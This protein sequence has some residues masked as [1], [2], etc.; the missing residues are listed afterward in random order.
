MNRSAY[1]AS[2]EAFLDADE[3]AILG[4][5]APNGGFSVE[6]AQLSAWRYQIRHLQDVL[7]GVPSDQPDA[8]IYFEFVIPRMGK[9]VDVLLVL[10]GLIFILEYK[11]GEK[12]YPAHAVDQ[13]VDYA[14]DL[15]NF[16]ETSHH[17]I[18]VPVLV[19]TD[20]PRAG[21][22]EFADSKDDRVL[23]PLLS[24]A[25]SLGALLSGALEKFPAERLPLAAWERGRYLPTPTI[26]EA[27]RALYA[28]H[29]V[30]DISRSDAGEVDIAETRGLVERVIDRC[31]ATST[32][33][34]CFVTGVPGAGKTLVG[35]D[36]AM[37][38]LDER[39]ERSRVFLS[40]N[41]P[42]VGILHEALARDRVSQARAAGETLR[43][44]VAKSQIKAFL[45]NV[46]HFR[47]SC[48]V[49]DR[50]PIEHVALFD[51]AQRAWD[52]EQTS[53]FMQQKKDRPGF[54]QSEPDFLI[55]CMG[56]HTDWAVVV[57]LVGGGQEIHT[58]ESGID[59]W[60]QAIRDH[61]KDWDVYA[62]PNLSDREYNAQKTLE[63]LRGEGRAELHPQLHLSSCVRSF[64]AESLSAW[65][66]A[67][68]DGDIGRARKLSDEF[69]DRYPI[70]LTRCLDT[71]KAWARSQARG[72]ER[73]GLVVSSQAQ[74]LKPYAI[75]VKSPM[76]PVNWFLNDKD[77]VRSSYFLE[78]VATEFQVQG[79]ELDWA[80]VA[81]DADLR[82]VQSPGEYSWSHHSFRGSKW[83]RIKQA[84]RQRYQLNAY[85]VLLTRA[86]QGMVIFVPEGD[87]SDPTRRP[88]FY[89]DT[90]RY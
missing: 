28:R 72:T 54:H 36:V 50:P 58:G 48:L 86:R 24:N 17:A 14:L 5:L 40:G 62:S 23:R 34:I 29:A 90:Y 13:V 15:K 11:V 83:Q 44:G 43:K 27:A 55:E 19:A 52:V 45:Q 18:V 53:R 74:R 2:I 68:L 42:L 39:A 3:A 69:Q 33:A 41:G 10:G 32:K 79:L 77:D 35:L 70:A 89:D 51:E 20:A 56:R 63:S 82:R 25:G 38:V 21:T 64:R 61:H 88:D 4:D 85:R 65:V 1:A 47:D 84:H 57:C 49:D 60:L 6:Q 81:W 31:R 75:D 12:R 78:D 37:K 67:V 66:K 9:R 59:G 71:A 87:Q 46:H 8:A 76:N 22:W 73:Y 30:E 7:A 16:H 26:V 80:C